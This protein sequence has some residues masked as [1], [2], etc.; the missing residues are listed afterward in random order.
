MAAQVIHFGW[1]DCCRVPVLRE[2]G[3]EVIEAKS[4]DELSADLQRNQK[5]DAVIVSEDVEPTAERVADMVRRSTLA[6]VLQRAGYSHRPLPES[7][8]HH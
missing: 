5:V 8:I 4:L 2:A 7:K 3:F 6:P 1:D